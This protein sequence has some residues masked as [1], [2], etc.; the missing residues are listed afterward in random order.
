MLESHSS[1]Q[2][3]SA[4]RMIAVVVGVNECD[5]DKIPRLACALNDAESVYT[6]LRHSHREA[7]FHV[8]ILT[9]PALNKDTKR[10]TKANILQAMHEAAD[11]AG[12]KDTL[13]FFFAGHG[14]MVDQRPCLMPCD[15]QLDA[16]NQE[17]VAASLIP[18]DELQDIFEGHPCQRRVMLID[19]CQGDLVLGNGTHDIDD[20]P[21][22][23]GAW[24]AG[25]PVSDSFVDAFQQRPRGWSVLLSCG[26][27]E[28]SLEDPQWGNHG[29]FSHFLSTGLRGEADLDGDGVVS[30]AEFAQYLA[31]R[32]PQQAEA[33][34]S[35][36][37]SLGEPTPEQ[38]AQHPTLI[39]GGPI[40]VPLTQAIR[41]ER[42]DFGRN[43]MELWGRFLVR[44]LPYKLPVQGMLR[45]GAFG[46]YGTLMACSAALAILS[47]NGDLNIELAVAIGA[48]SAV[49][50]TVA[51][52]LVGASTVSHWHSGGYFASCI[53]LAWHAIL[54]IAAAAYGQT[55]D[56]VSAAQLGRLG[57]TLF[58]T[59]SMMVV[60]AFN[61]IQS[62]LA[63]AEAL[64]FFGPVVMR[65][66]FMQL[67]ENRV[68][69]DIP[70]SIPMVSAHP[71][72]YH[73]VGA[74]CSIAVIVH[75]FY[76]AWA[77]MPPL[78]TGLSVFQD[79][80]ALVMIQWLV[81]WY[82]AAYRAIRSQVL[83]ER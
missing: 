52:A 72:V 2:P 70:N 79:L 32:V 83:P 12:A 45:Y 13:V 57:V 66:A 71:L 11:I 50:W 76:A 43:V 25:L 30:L 53:L 29:I 7:E 73:I 42:T 21:Q 47:P 20:A 16:G 15:V 49:L 24:R 63:F 68:S 56:G 27:N 62:I 48:I 22:E 82:C 80:I 31:N 1:V 58:A 17:A 55:A 6:T 4:S 28:V 10:A 9:A 40:D 36:L 19:C 38:D 26:P 77:D 18:V 67:D 75:A 39:W 51:F 46:L 37:R 61:V 60:F 69:A 8:M 59:I 14:G 81:Q 23:S 64:D 74:V 33:I 44:P 78:E 54:F 65:Q 3:A 34:I 35:Y 5:N 41:G